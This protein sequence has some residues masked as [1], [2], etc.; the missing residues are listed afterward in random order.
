MKE[1]ALEREEVLGCSLSGSGPS[2][3]VLTA[4]REAAHRAAD[5]MVEALDVSESLDAD[6]F[7]SEVGA[8]GAR[9]LDDGEVPC[10]L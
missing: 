6:V 2:V 5:R 4:S 1:A 7:V 10:A 9:V 3:F 8:S